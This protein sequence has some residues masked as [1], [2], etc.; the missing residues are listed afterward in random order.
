MFLSDGQFVDGG[1]T[2]EKGAAE[3]TPLNIVHQSGSHTRAEGPQDALG[4][5]GRGGIIGFRF[6]AGRRP[7]R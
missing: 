7:S 2:T 6:G 5:T 1:P 4:A 3:A